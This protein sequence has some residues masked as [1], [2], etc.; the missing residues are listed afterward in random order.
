MN[1]YK[2]FEMFMGDNNWYM[3]ESEIWLV[4]WMVHVHNGK[5]YLPAY[6][7]DSEF[8]LSKG[9]TVNMWV[10]WIDGVLTVSKNA[11]PTRGVGFNY[12]RDF[13]EVHIEE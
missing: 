13:I 2:Y 11:E 7:N 9:G 12:D 5:Y 1:E 6:L 4:P 10:K 3:D 8:C